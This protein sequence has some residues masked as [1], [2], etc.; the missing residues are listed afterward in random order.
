MQNSKIK[1]PSDRSPSVIDT[2]VICQGLGYVSKKSDQDGDETEEESA[3]AR[4][5]LLKT[6]QTLRLEFRQILKIDNLHVLTSLTRLFL[7]NNFIERVINSLKNHYFYNV[8][9]LQ[10]SGLDQLQHLIWL[11][12]SFNKIRKIE[13]LEALKKLEVL[14][15]FGNEI[16]KVEGLDHMADLKVLRL[17]RNKIAAK[18]EIIQLRRLPALRTLSIKENPFCSGMDWEGDWKRSFVFKN[19]NE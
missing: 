2:D 17:G 4:R 5:F 19:E 11:D 6:S 9:C 16:G 18:D 3:A 10:I 14:A 15:L 12:L 13:G 8:T 1:L 7:D